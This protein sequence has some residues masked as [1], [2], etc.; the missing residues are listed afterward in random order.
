MTEQAAPTPRDP[1]ASGKQESAAAH[2]QNPADFGRVDPDGTVHVRTAAGERVVGQMPDTPLD[3]AMAFYTKRYEALA[4]TVELL[5]KRIDAGSVSPDEAAHLIKKERQ[6]IAEAS[7]VGDLDALWARLDALAPK[8]A[9]QREVRRAEK[10]EHQAATRTTKEGYVAEAERLAAGN[11]WRGGVNKFRDLLEKWKALPRI[12]KATDD[13][14][15]HRFS[16]AR[17]TYTRRRKA[18]FAE[19]AHK[20]DAA[21]D[22]KRRIITEAEALADSTDWGPTSGAFRDLMTRWKAAGPAP[23]EV[24]DKLWATFRGLQDKFFEA[25]TAANA[26][27]DKEY[28]GNQDAKEA[29]LAEYEPQIRP[30]DDLDRAKT[31]YRELLDKWSEIG[32]VPRDA[33]RPLDQRMKALENAIK[34]VEDDRWKRTNPEARA[35]AEDTAD[36][37]RSQ[38]AEQETKAEKAEARGDNRAAEQAHKAAETY[39]TWLEQAEA[40]VNDFSG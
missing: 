13:E 29:L 12:D 4:V 21:A 28:K 14:L 36:K 24:D 10:A 37:L 18:Q 30:T 1:A 17:T 2:P 22:E 40:A 25:R 39:R 26:E 16:S 6:A 35:R 20:R 7:A 19:Q 32:K 27:Q 23:R 33:I 5:E 3:E 11:D 15:W 9:E 31:A 34:K 38:I 8:L